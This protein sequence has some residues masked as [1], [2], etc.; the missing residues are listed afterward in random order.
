[1]GGSLSFYGYDGHGSV[2]LLTDASAAVTDTYDYDAFGNLISRT[3]STPNDYLYS[4]EQFD[5]QLGFYYLRA[6]YMNPS[7][8]KFWTADSFEGSP[9]D[10]LS[11][12]KYLYAN[13]DPLNRRDPSGEFSLIDTVITSS[14]IGTVSG[15]GLGF[16]TGGIKGAVH[17]ALQGAILGALV[18]L[19]GA[20]VGTVLLGNAARGVFLAGALDW[21]QR[22]YQVTALLL[23]P[24]ERSGLKPVLGS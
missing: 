15:A 24:Q 12:H 14:L 1:M 13:A 19:T 3:G 22:G 23:P 6:R 10:P 16:I 4:G 7:S 21:D 11:L 18:P 17:G 9:F 5:A 2:R 20:G 8:G